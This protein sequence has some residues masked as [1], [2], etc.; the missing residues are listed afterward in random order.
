MTLDQ[1]AR[2]SNLV[3]KS[4]MEKVAILAYFH[5]RQ[6]QLKE[7]GMSDVTSWMD[8]LHLGQPNL[9]RLAN[10][11]ITTG[12]CVK[13]LGGN[14]KLHARTIARLEAEL[15]QLSEVAEDI[16]SSGSIIPVNLTKGTRGYIERLAE[17]INASYE[18]SIFDGCAVLMRRLLE[19]LLIQTYSHLKIDSHIQVAPDQY[20]DLKLIIADAKSNRTLAL[21]KGTKDVMDEFR[22]LG[23]FSAHKIIYNCRREEIKNV[24][25]EYRA[26]V[27]ELL[28]KSGL[29][30]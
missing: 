20:K 4:E 14:L 1:L 22:I 23:N 8:A 12:A 2:A 30:K 17:Q 24:A 16:V 28:Y 27:E 19:V 9:S 21:S 18:Q 25:R 3:A 29:R 13:G 6:T 7:F 11:L 26:G 5:F 15:P 10:K